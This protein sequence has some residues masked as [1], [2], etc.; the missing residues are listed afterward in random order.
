MSLKIKGWRKITKIAVGA[1]FGLLLLIFFVKVATFEDAYYREKEGS[2]R[3]VSP[4]QTEEEIVPTET[5]ELSEEEPTEVQIREYWVAPERPRYLTI[6]KLGIYNS[7]VRAVSINSNGELGTPNNIFD[8]G[9][10]E[11]SGLPGSGRTLL[12]DGHNG[13]PHVHGV[14]KN[15]PDLVEGDIVWIERGDT[16]LFKYVVVENVEKSLDEANTYMA[17]AMK[18]PEPGRESLTL[19]SCTGEWS[20]QRNTYLS[21][22]FVR[23]VFDGS[24][25]NE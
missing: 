20:S 19:I 4:S 17:T 14:F 15:L 6:E 5:E 12:I 7:R 8:V 23:A 11:S 18:S 21:R 9:W 13:G 25:E 16:M 22:Q 24:F 1:V 2:E 3:A 10:Y